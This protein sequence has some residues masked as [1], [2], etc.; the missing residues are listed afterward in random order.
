MKK[1]QARHMM[2]G[3]IIGGI[4]V[5]I[6]AVAVTYTLMKSPTDP[7]PQSASQDFSGKIICAPKK[8]GSAATTECDY[9]IQTDDG[10]KY[11]L[12]VARLPNNISIQRYPVDTSVVATGT[13]T[14]PGAEQQVYDVDGTIGVTALRTK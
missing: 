5:G 6:I 11:L 9:A 3:G 2:L 12:Y 7:A 4:I 10:K 8:A 13:V 14:A 1:Q